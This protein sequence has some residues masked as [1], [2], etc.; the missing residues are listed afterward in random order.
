MRLINKLEDVRKA[1]GN[2]IRCTICTYSGWPDNYTICPMYSYDKCFTYSGGGFMYLAKSLI[3]KKLIF[4][5]KVSDLLY[6]C[7]GC[8]ACDDICEII[9][10]SE[11]YFSHFDIV[12]L[13]RREAVK[14]GLIK[15]KKFK[16]IQAQ[17]QSY[18]EAVLSTKDNVLGIPEKI[19]DKNA[20]RLLF[21]EWQFLTSQQKIYKSVLNLLEKIGEPIGGIS[22]RGL[23]FPELYDLGFWNELEEYL[24]TKFD[25]KLLKGKELIFINPHLEEFIKSRLPEII[26]GYENIKTRHISEVLLEALKEEKLRRKKGLKGVKVSFHDPCYLGRGLKIYEPPREVLSLMDSIE[27]IEM[28]RNKKDSFCCGARA[29]DNYFQDFSKKTALE[30]LK[31]FKKTGAD[32]LITACPYCKGIFQKITFDKRNIVKDITEFIE[33]RIE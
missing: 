1:V 29:G 3:D 4:D 5:S 7:S 2:C 22:D 17:I 6:T 16:S 23:S 28:D 33:E 25:I 15:D 24:T 9:P 14:R 31:E 11:P 13:M 30:R 18:E 19:F 8:L 12:R 21:V 26:S 32:L 27:L 20:K 10:Y